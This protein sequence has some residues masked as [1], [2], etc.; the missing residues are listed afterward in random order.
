MFY[1]KNKCIKTKREKS[2]Y[3]K[4]KSLVAFVMLFI[5]FSITLLPITSKASNVKFDNCILTKS[6]SIDQN[7]TLQTLNKICNE[8]LLEKEVK[9]SAVEKRFR[10]EQ[11]LADEP[12]VII[13]HNKNYILPISY[14]DNINQAVYLSDNTSKEL[15]N[16]EAKLQ[17]SFKVPLLTDSLF[18]KGDSISFGFTLQSWW[19]MYTQELSRPF[20]ET[21][22]QPEIFYFTPLDVKISGGKTGLFL[23]IEHQSNGLSQSRQLSRSWNRIYVNFIFAKDNFALSFCPWWRIPEGDKVTTPEEPGN[24]NPDISDY[25]GNF[26]L[27]TVYKWENV[28]FSAKGRENF[29]EHKGAIEIGITFPL[30]GKL[31]GYFQY[32]NG[33]GDSLIDYNHSQERFGLGIA[34]NDYF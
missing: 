22:Y 25:M 31:R 17:I 19:Q 34:L 7:M 15:K 27:M 11:K 28:E 24:D 5:I 30:N 3:M 4:Y 32:F 33:Y 23:G 12:F 29:K 20:R 13:P 1:M 26:E 8:E 16:M 10:S 6:S 2:N 18:I 14:T 21:N 9:H